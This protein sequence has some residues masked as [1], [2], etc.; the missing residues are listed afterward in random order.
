[1]FANVVATVAVFM[2]RTTIVVLIRMCCSSLYCTIAITVIVTMLTMM[3]MMVMIATLILSICRVFELLLPLLS[4]RK[5][6][7]DIYIYIYIYIYICM[8]IGYPNS[9]FTKGSAAII[10]RMQ[11]GSSVWCPALRLMRLRAAQESAAKGRNSTSYGALEA[12]NP[13]LTNTS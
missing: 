4:V 6:Y 12:S 7:K 10:M 9:V 5:P 11:C 13:K 8:Y 3:T 1:M 2:S